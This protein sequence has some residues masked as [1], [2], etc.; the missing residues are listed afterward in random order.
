MNPF[1]LS[2]IVMVVGAAALGIVQMWTGFLAWDIFFKAMGTIA[3]LFV[4]SGLIYVLQS[5]LATKK[6]LKDENYLD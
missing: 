2:L 4:V 6:K 5:D 3:I 1:L